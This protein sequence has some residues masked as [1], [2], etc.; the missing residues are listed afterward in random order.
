MPEKSSEGVTVDAAQLQI[1]NSYA[2]YN[3]AVRSR[4]EERVPSV[5]NAACV[6][7]APSEVADRVAKRLED[8]QLAMQAIEGDLQRIK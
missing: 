3:L 2:V 1:Q 5:T 6:V 4:A 7:R 8:V